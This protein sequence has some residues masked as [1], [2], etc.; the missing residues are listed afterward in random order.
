MGRGHPPVA[1]AEAGAARRGGWAA[2][3]AAPPVVCSPAAAAARLSRASAA[4]AEGNACV[5]RREWEAAVR[6]YGAALS[7]LSFEAPGAAEAGE[8]R[9]LRLAAHANTALCCLRLARWEEAVRS[10]DAALAIDAGAVKAWFRRAS[11]LLELGRLAEALDAT[12]QT[13]ELEP[14]NAEATQL[15][16]KVLRAMAEQR[17]QEALM[18]RRMF[19][20]TA[21]AEAAP[22]GM[23]A[24][25]APEEMET[26]ATPTAAAPADAPPPGGSAP[27][28]AGERAD[29]TEGGGERV[30]EEE[31][32]R[33]ECRSS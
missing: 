10:A 30:G 4:R 1:E 25:A 26:E 22:A 18:F 12:R 6:S 8:Q 7:E 9:A 5:G 15:R 13:L 28:E 16:Q 2:R 31:A 14:A 11:A 24:E 32:D 27:S 21:E 29:E 3:M 20:S 33:S 17:R 19:E 23:Q